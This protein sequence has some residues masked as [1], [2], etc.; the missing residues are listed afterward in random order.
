MS[1]VVAHPRFHECE[2]Q[3][4]QRDGSVEEARVFDFYSASY[5]LDVARDGWGLSVLIG[6]ASVWD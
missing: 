4:A 5:C 1:Y 2:S 6:F 3:R